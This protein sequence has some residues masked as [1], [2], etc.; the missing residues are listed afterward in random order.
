MRKKSPV[1]ASPP[2][3]PT[4]GPTTKG[5]DSYLGKNGQTP[6]WLSRCDAMPC[7]AMQRSPFTIHSFYVRSTCTHKR[8]NPTEPVGSPIN[9]QCR[10]RPRPGSSL[11]NDDPNLAKMLTPCNPGSYLEPFCR[12]HWWQGDREQNDTVRAWS[13]MTLDPAFCFASFPIQLQHPGFGGK[14]PE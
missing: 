5:H 10:A 14:L 12:P 1:N 2:T 13:M 7:H 3:Q 6:D 8:K 11:R 9:S 4:D